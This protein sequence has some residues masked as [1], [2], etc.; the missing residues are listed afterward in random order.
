MFETFQARKLMRVIE[1]RHGH[2]QPWVVLCEGKSGLKEFVVKVFTNDHLLD[3]PRVHG[4]FVGSWLCG[5]FELL[6]PDVAWIEMDSSFLSSLPPNLDLKMD[7]TDDRPK[8]GSVVLPSFQHFSPGLNDG[9]FRSLLPVDRLYAFD[10]FIR[11]ADRG[12]YK[13]NL[14]IS[15]SSAYLIDHEFALEIDETTI[16]GI[17]NSILP[18]KFSLD[19]IAYAVLARASTRS[20]RDFF[21]DFNVYLR[22]LNLS[23]LRAVFNEVQN[24][25]YDA[26]V[27]T[28]MDYFMF[29]KANPSIFTNLLLREIQ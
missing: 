25:G 17:K 24:K 27:E 5:E 23:D 3:K 12:S 4:E 21:A 22:A 2:T 14:L 28:I 11:N 13:P 15:E 19:H 6:T 10:V 8:F 20:K 7:P 9:Y 26:K 18:G 16:E 29:V 1:E